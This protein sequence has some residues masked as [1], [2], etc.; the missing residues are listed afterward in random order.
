MT[1]S[2]QLPTAKFQLG[3]SNLHCIFPLLR[4]AVTSILKQKRQH[5]HAKC[6][7]TLQVLKNSDVFTIYA[8]L[9]G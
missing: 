7:K 4:L 1:T 2:A 8:N 5:M 3:M 6:V 9:A